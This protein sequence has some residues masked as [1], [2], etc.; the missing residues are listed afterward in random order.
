MDEAIRWKQCFHNYQKASLALQNAVE[1]SRPRLLTGLE[2]QGTIH[3][4]EFTFELAWNVM[5][6]YLEEQGITGIIG[7]KEAIRHAFNKGIIDEGQVWM[8][9]IKDRNIASHS[10]DEK[11]AE[12]LVAA[13]NDTYYNHLRLFADKMKTLDT[14]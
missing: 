6:D 10:Y 8:D 7:S 14:E 4:F 2:R 3:I 11:T 5:K 1:L 12:D 13:I 9:M